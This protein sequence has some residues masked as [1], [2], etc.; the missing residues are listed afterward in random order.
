MVRSFGDLGEEARGLDS[1]KRLN[2]G[3]LC[4]D[5]RGNIFY[6]FSYLAEPTVRKFDRFGYAAYEI[7]LAAD[8]FSG[9]APEGRRDVL[10]L[11]RRGVPA[12]KSAIHAIG[13]DT[14]SGDTWIG[15][16]NALVRFDKDGARRSTHHLFL[17]DGAPL[18][19]KVILVEPE[20]VL[21]G[22][23]PIGIFEFERPGRNAAAAST[24]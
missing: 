6:V 24:K 13:V 9:E 10:T 12:P 2:P 21:A 17:P 22:V 8:E 19:P 1:S 23:D 4:G 3:W 5:G 16:A 7:S 18:E 15:I 14:A 11:E 20:R